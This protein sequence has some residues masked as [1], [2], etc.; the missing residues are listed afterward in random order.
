MPRQSLIQLAGFSAFMALA[1]RRFALDPDAPAGTTPP[2]NPPATPPAAPATPPVTQGGAPA[3]TGAIPAADLDKLAGPLLQ[4]VE[5]AIDG[6][7][8]PVTQA[9]A[10]LDGRI[11]ELSKPR[12]QG[13]ASTL[14]GGGA[15]GTRTGEDPLTSRGYQ[16]A[17]VAGLKQG[18]QGL[19]RDNCKVEMQVHEKLYKF[20]VEQ[21]GL[22]LAGKDSILVPFGSAE[23]HDFES[24]LANE[25]RQ[26][27]VAGITG[28]N[29]DEA[30]AMVIQ[31]FA[32][33]GTRAV[34]QA[35]S[36]FDDTA[37][38]VFTEGG[39]M[40]E[41]IQLVRAREC[42]SRAG[43]TQL[44]LPPNGYLPFPKQTGATTAYWVGEAT[45]IDTSE[46]ATGRMEMRAKKLAARV[47]LPNE[48][49]RFAT[50]SVE[51]FIRADIARVLA[52]KA[53]RTFLDAV[54]STVSPKGLIN[55]SGVQTYTAGT[56]A[57][58]GNQFEPEDPA[59]MLAVVEESDYDLEVERWAWMMRPKM[60]KN[61]RVRR[62]GIYNGSS[63]DDT[64]GEWLFDVNRGD[65]RNGAPTMLEGWP[66][67][68]SSQ[69]SG[70]H[71]KGVSTDLTYIL[72]GIFAH[73]LIARMGVMEIAT[74]TQGDTDFATDQTSL[75]AIQHMDAAPRYENAFVVCDSLDM[76]LPA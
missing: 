12:R 35:L 47:R 27:L 33:M 66:V 43:A 2:A 39:Q 62:A 45:S 6:R 71:A 59:G 44:T 61:L 53:D 4:S 51:A 7:L 34:R 70:A 5:K 65:I 9:V 16:F 48:L 58:D 11:D 37:L 40:G 41:L 67:I 69:I 49:L 25:I 31:H 20:F 10:K 68:K 13:V 42:F 57:N 54:G 56:V 21:H 1:G 75:R 24:N 28:A 73:F 46:V 76:D 32:G 38:G 72:G 19:S 60:W 36:M 50:P 23:I 17:R 64:K 52:L 29:A 18:A 14:F 15:P 22:S 74:A 55:Y 8:A 63:V 3:A 26:C 30:Q